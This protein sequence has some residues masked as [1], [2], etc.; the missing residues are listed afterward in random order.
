MTL[1]VVSLSVCACVFGVWH[2]LTL[3]SHTDTIKMT[4]NTSSDRKPF[5]ALREEH[6][7]EVLK[8]SLPH[9]WCHM[10]KAAHFIPGE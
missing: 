10:L 2:R 4:P 8:S 9:W 6:S 5:T 1:Q 3:G 7:R